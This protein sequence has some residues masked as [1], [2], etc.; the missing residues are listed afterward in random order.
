MEKS[1]L[2]PRELSGLERTGDLSRLAP[3]EA[4][5]L[6]ASRPAALVDGVGAA[7]AGSGYGTAGIEDDDAARVAGVAGASRLSA[8]R[9]LLLARLSEQRL[10]G[11]A[12]EGWADAPARP[13]SRRRSRIPRER[14]GPMVVCLDTSHSMVGGREALAKAV[15]VEAVRASHAQGRA[16]LIFAFS[17]SHDLAELRLAPPPSSRGTRANSPTSR[18]QAGAALDRTTLMRLLDF[19]SYSFGGGTDVAGPLRRALAI[20]E[21]RAVPGAD[22]IFAGADVLLVSDGV[23]PAAFDATRLQ[24]LFQTRSPHLSDLTH[25]AIPSVSRSCPTRLLTTRHSSDSSGCVPSAV[26]TAGLQP[27]HIGSYALYDSAA[28]VCSKARP[29]HQLV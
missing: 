2:A 9:K 14:G 16:C 17:G 23:G 25:S 11:Y 10:L 26:P 18:R 1:R 24:D 21:P 4:S 5:L 22:A 12:L 19:L 8:C 15:V 29:L 6:A 13:S 20:L 7:C 28:P 3:M 27:V